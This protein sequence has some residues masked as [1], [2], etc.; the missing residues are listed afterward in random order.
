MYQTLHIFAFLKKH[1]KLTLYM[2]P[3]LPCIDYGDF[4]TNKKEDFSEIYRDAEKLLPHR[5]PVPRG[6]GTT[7]TAFVDASH[8]ANTVR[9]RSHTGYVVF[10]NRAPVVWYSKHQNTVVEISTFSSEFIVLI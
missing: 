4:R 5:M 7:M 8:A 6:R 9:R 10:I 2:S 3:E 1:P